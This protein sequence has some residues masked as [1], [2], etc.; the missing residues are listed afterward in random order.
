MTI[1]GLQGKRAMPPKIQT[2]LTELRRRCEALYGER[3]VRMVLFGS[4]A[5]GDAEPSSDIDVMV[6]LRGPV[7]PG[8]EIARTSEIK[9]AL[10]LQYDVVIS[11]TYV[12][13]DRYVTER[14]PLLLNVRREG[15]EIYETCESRV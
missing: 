15:V 13:A 7:A 9:A 8:D 2:I 3:L 11:C 10:S 1:Q 4:Q 12:S 6:V 5:R 14:S